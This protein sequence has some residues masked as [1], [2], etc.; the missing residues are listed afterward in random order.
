MKKIFTLCLS[1]MLLVG[2]SMQATPI[3]TFEPVE[4]ALFYELKVY[5]NGRL[6]ATARIDANGQLAGDII[7]AALSRIGL[8]TV[9]TD[10]SVYQVNLSNLEFGKDY[11]FTLDT[12]DEN[13]E[14][15][16]AQNPAEP[17]K[18]LRDGRLYILLPNGTKYDAEGRV[19]E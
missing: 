6:V 5:L 2:M 18:V 11:T 10:P 19:V 3:I 17:V 4:D 15:I 13:E 14:C 16:S 7:W 1:M 8:R 9:D 12:Y